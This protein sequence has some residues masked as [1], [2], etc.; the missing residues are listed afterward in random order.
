[1]WKY[2]HYVATILKIFQT[3]SLEEVNVI[4]TSRVDWDVYRNK[5]L[6]EHEK[7]FNVLT[8]LIPIRHVICMN[9][10]AFFMTILKRSVT[11]CIPQTF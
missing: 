6:R 4:T 8:F 5:Y 10:T 1:M 2:A 11:S 9:E 3:W 7:S